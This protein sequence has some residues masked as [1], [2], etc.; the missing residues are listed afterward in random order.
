MLCTFHPVSI[1]DESNDHSLF[2]C[3]GFTTLIF[4]PLPL[5][6]GRKPYTLAAFALMLPLMF[7]QALAVSGYRSPYNPIYRCGLLIPRAFQGV[8]MGFANI[9]FLP[10]LFD[11]FGASLMSDK[12]HQEIVV[13]DDVR[14]QGGGIGVWLG[15]WSFCFVGSMSIGFCVGAVIISG[16]SPAWGFYIVVILLAFFLLVN[17]IAPE[18]RRAPYRRSIAQYVDEDE[19]LR[20]RVA[21]GEVKLHISNEG[22]MWWYQEVWAGLILTTRMLIQP[23]FFLLAL[24]LAWMYAQVTLVILV[25]DRGVLDVHSV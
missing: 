20:R 16:I 22:P 9:N 14:R 7:P 23:G 25:S 4:W 3:L 24:Y 17:V 18:T 2:A 21:R 19:K 8:A 12:P 6:H 11:L 13:Y 5:L 15:I 1:Q 10:T